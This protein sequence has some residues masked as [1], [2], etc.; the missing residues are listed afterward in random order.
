MKKISEEPYDEELYAKL[1]DLR[2]KISKQKSLPPFVIFQNISLKEMAIQKPTSI[3]EM[4][5]ISGVGQ[6][7]AVKHGRPF[8]NTIRAHIK[9]EE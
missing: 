4:T 2:I 7:R 9:E 3:D 1:K 5:K 6:G 8:L